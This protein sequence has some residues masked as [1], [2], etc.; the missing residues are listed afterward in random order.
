MSRAQRELWRR[1]VCW[2][3]SVAKRRVRE[4]TRRFIVNKFGGFPVV[5]LKKFRFFAFVFTFMNAF[6]HQLRVPLN[7]PLRVN[8]R[9]LAIWNSL[10]PSFFFLDSKHE[11][12]VSETWNQNTHFMRAF[13]TVLRNI[14]QR[15]SK[16]NCPQSLSPGAET[17]L[18]SK[19]F[20]CFP[21]V[22]LMDKSRKASSKSLCWHCKLKSPRGAADPLPKQRIYVKLLHAS[23][24]GQTS[25]A[26]CCS[27]PE[28]GRTETCFLFSTQ[29]IFP[30]FFFS[31]CV[32]LIMVEWIDWTAPATTTTTSSAT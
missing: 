14:C 17:F 8:E 3:G 4:S 6:N 23:C 10:K 28:P 11:I 20:D 29:T 25:A 7:L 15:Q 22:F 31:V 5:F 19:I 27:D 12:L 1:D 30:F 21:N 9:V 18:L 26:F 2:R 32:P 24:S 13:S 16:S